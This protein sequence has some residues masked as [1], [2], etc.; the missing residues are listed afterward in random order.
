MVVIPSRPIQKAP[1]LY[2]R[3]G[4]MTWI[5]VVDFNLII[6]LSYKPDNHNVRRENLVTTSFR[7]FATSDCEDDES[8]GT[9]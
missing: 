5:A 7:S 4:A 3:G 9:S 8:T 1:D 6:P 2:D